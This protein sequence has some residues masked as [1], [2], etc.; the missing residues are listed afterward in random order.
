MADSLY[1][2]DYNLNNSDY[3]IKKKSVVKS[4]GY[5]PKYYPGTRLSSVKSEFKEGIQ[6]VIKSS[7]CD[8]V[9]RQ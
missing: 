9:T 1:V 4:A 7:S 6:G 3:A 2:S 5:E 8:A